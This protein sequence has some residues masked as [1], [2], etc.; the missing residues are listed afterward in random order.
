MPPAK[1]TSTPTLPGEA[2][3]LLKGFR[4][5]RLLLTLAR[6]CAF[7]AGTTALFLIPALLLDRFLLLETPQ[8][9]SISWT[10]LSASGASMFFFLVLPLL[11]P[12]SLLRCAAAI[13]KAQPALEGSLLSI[14]E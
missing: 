13:E 11:R 12:W 2:L 14:V 9:S 8:R 4:R 1:T 10:T 6:G 7:W 5:R 3:Q